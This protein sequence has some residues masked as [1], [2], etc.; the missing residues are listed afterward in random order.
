VTLETE[1]QSTVGWQS[2]EKCGTLAQTLFDLVA[3]NFYIESY[4]ACRHYLQMLS[5]ISTDVLKKYTDVETM[6][7]YRCALNIDSND[8]K[9]ADINTDDRRIN[10]EL[11]AWANC[12]RELGRKMSECNAPLRMEKSYPPNF[13]FFNQQQT[14]VSESKP[15]ADFKSRFFQCLSSQEEINQL[16][17]YD[18]GTRP[19]HLNGSYPRNFLNWRCHSQMYPN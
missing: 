5:S 17:S 8:K 11:S 19:K 16:V 3:Y 14:R 1:C 13:E 18:A 9:S 4:G 6:Q 12:N 7:G 15:A 10:L 2:L